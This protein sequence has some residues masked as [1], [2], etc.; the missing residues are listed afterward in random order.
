[1]DEIAISIQNLSKKYRLYN[2]PRERF[3]EA[4][5]PFR[6]KYHREFWALK[7]INFNIK[8]GTTV[9]IVGRNG[10]GKSTLLQ[11][12]C[13]VLK[14]TS[15]EIHVNGRISALL[16]LGAG[17][18]PQFTGRENVLLN[19]QISGIPLVEM[20]KRLPEIEAFADI[21][22]FIDQPVKTYS[23][24]MF[25]RLAF[26]AAINVDPDILVVDEALAVGDAK[27]Q[28]KCYSKFL[29]FQ[30]DGKTVLF[31]TH[32]ANAIVR[33]CDS[34]ILLEKGK[35]LEIGEPKA[36]TNYYI[37]FLFM[38]KISKSQLPPRLVEKNYRGFSIVHY[39]LKYFAILKSL[40]PIDLTH[41]E[42]SFLRM[43]IE[44]KKCAVDL[45]CEKV[46]QLVDGIV[47]ED[48][49]SHDIITFV[50]GPGSELDA[51][52]R[53]KQTTDNS[54]NRKNYNKNEYRSGSED[55]EI[56][57]YLIVAND[58]LD[59]CQLESGEHVDLY[60]KVLFQK[61]VAFPIYGFSINTKEGVSVYGWNTCMN[62]TATRP[63]EKGNM[64][65]VKFS[66]NMPLN[67]NDYFINLG[68]AENQ[69]DKQVLLKR[70]CG[71]IHVL[72]TKHYGH[73]FTGFVDLNA[74]FEE[75]SD[76]VYPNIKKGQG[77]K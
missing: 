77:R 4:L 57:D 54:I 3:L 71:I 49:V 65:V 72:V 8:K 10:S 29:E 14:P 68:V 48:K 35:I 51:F 6:K 15:G 76:F 74:G 44:E 63:M 22:D 11:L 21:G 45:S 52:L 73:S 5:H 50:R 55:V 24:G 60:I 16:E 37:D 27:F 18:D 62:N 28:H 19:G 20:K 42:G 30:K 38:G 59:V 56:L 46:K 43:L 23:S 9:G 33:H 25:L 41:I 58:A 66:F 47:Q 1:M 61:R 53:E 7:N 13:S 75:I 39:R 2:S 32:D 31:A 26:A 34:A 12:I 70:R 40:G 64:C 69:D 17:F 67:G 36:V